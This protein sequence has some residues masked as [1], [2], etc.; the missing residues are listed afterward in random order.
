MKPSGAA[1]LAIVALCVFCGVGYGIIHDQITAQICPQYF[2]VDHPALG[3][4]AIFHSRSPTVLGL[5][6]G[7]VATA[8]LAIFF[9]V[10][11]A[12]AAQA[13]D[14]PRVAPRALTLPLA[15][16]L[17]FMAVCALAGGLLGHRMGTALAQA[18]SDPTPGA[19]NMPTT[20][21]ELTDLY[22]HGAS[23]SGGVV[24]GL[25]L[26]LG[27]IQHRRRAWQKSKRQQ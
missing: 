11:L 5:A 3:W 22:A 9:G 12:L 1:M 4:P 6:W 17:L 24:V 14:W 27:T 7:I 19:N 10:M 25:T 20:V 26:T 15:I 21:G 8:P 23:Y 18:Q 16:G 2:T 13:G